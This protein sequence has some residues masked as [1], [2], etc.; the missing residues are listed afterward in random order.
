MTKSLAI[1]YYD[2]WCPKDI[3]RTLGPELHTTRRRGD[4][5]VD[6]VKMIIRDL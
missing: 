4:M 1:S 5:V 6:A 2:G 3:L